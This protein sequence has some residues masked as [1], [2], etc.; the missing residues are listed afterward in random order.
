MTKVAIVGAGSMAKE[1]IRAFGALEGVRVTGLY[2]RTREKAE[3]LASEYNINNVCNSVAELKQESDAD[4]VVVAVPE[5]AANAVAKEVLNHD[6]AVFLEKPAGYDFSDAKDIA[7]VAKGHQKPVMVGLN[8]RFY[9]SLQR[10]L[11]DVEQIDDSRYVHIQDQQNYEEARFHGHPEEVVQKFMYANS[12]H[13]IDMIFCLCRGEV[14]HVQSIMPW[15]GADTEVVLAHVTFD[16]GDT[17]LYEGIWKGPGP[18]SCSLSTPIRRWVMQ[19]L[20]KAAYQNAN[21]RIQN[22]VEIDPVDV[23]F[24]AGF[25]RQAEAVVARV[26]GEDSPVA[27]I[28]DSLNTM[29]LINQIFGV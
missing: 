3:A 6:W 27:S 18:W 10:V 11:G 16:S 25:L 22:S 12:I 4:L 24:K 21:E 26:R 8:R 23:E 20:E 19:P 7:V 2:S 28:E 29:K 17:A 13:V 14:K 15:K 9:S 5:L 1:H